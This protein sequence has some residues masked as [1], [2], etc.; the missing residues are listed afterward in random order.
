MTLARNVGWCSLSLVTG[1][2]FGAAIVNSLAWPL[3]AVLIAVFLR[4]QLLTAFQRMKSLEFPGGKAEFDTLG[5]VEQAVAVVA[6]GTGSAADGPAAR[7]D[8]AEF[9]VVQALIENAPGQAVIDAWQLLEY[10]LNMA[11]DRVDPDGPHGWP[12]VA[13][14]LERWDKWRT[15]FPAVLELRR[16][17]DYTVRSGRQPSSA[18]AARYVSVAQEL[19]AAL[20]TAFSPEP[21]E[22]TG[23]HG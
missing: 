1:L 10:H 15:L 16:L 22:L 12:Q 5:K 14:N 18:A 4:K 19:V 6:S 17:R 13:Q 20:R 8:L 21:A 9:S 2:Q 7:H 11:A 3:A 23:G